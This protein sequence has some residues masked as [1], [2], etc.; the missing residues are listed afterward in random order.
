MKCLRHA[1]FQVESTISDGDYTNRL[2][3]P[4]LSSSFFFGLLSLPSQRYHIIYYYFSANP[5]NPQ[6]IYISKFF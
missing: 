4:Q 5:Q 6:F 2:I 1:P 3:S